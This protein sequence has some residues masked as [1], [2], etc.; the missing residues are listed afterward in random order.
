MP[1]IRLALARGARSHHLKVACNERKRDS[2]MKVAVFSDVQGNL[3]AMQVAVE[4]ILAWQPELVVMNG[5][6][7]NRGPNSLGCLELFERLRLESGWIPLRGNHED[8]VLSCGRS[9]A[10]S[11][12][13]A[14]MRR[15]ADWTHRQLGE[16]IGLVDSWPDHLCFHAPEADNWVHVTHGTLLGNRDGISQSV[17]DER[18]P[19][20]LPEDIDV[21]VTAHTHKPLQRRFGATQILNVGSVGSP[22]DGDTRVSYGQLTYRHGLWDTQIVRL[23]YDRDQTEREFRQSGFIDEG[24]PLA[25]II[26]E[27]W[28]RAELL[29]P[30]WHRRYRDAVLEGRI[31]LDRAVKEF[32]DGLD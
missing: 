16:R 10:T 32:L 18:L 14:H 29:M 13:D 19:E 2:P 12:I 8:F 30:H 26:Y 6:L 1:S 17:P 11:A 7:I 5:D 27:E 4:H 3:P 20:K 21:F 31:S 22:F 15:F 25:A 28:R 23:P 24:G 9:P